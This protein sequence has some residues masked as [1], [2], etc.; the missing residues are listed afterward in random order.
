MK[1]SASMKKVALVTGGT[2][3][4]GLA[5]AQLLREKGCIVY[6]LSRSASPSP[7]HI[8]CDVC[9]EV[10]C[11]AA[12]EAIVQKEGRLDILLHCAG[13]GISGA[14][15]FTPM[16]K[17]EQ[18]MRVNLL[19][20]ANMVNAC[21]APMRQQGGGRMVLTS[22]VAGIVPIP[23][24]TW[25][26]CSKAAINSYTMSMA[27]ELKPFHITLCAVLPGDTATGFT[28]ARDKVEAGDEVYG[29]TIGRS[30]GKMEQDEQQGASPKKVAALMV[31]CALKKR[32]KPFYVPGFSYKCVALLMRLLPSGPANTLIG[33]LYASDK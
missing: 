6:T 23:F 16:E 12:V 26:A 32:V 25:Y 3:G 8:P 4:I 29:G 14:G 27:N 19:G 28:A 20:T 30:V 17:A 21:I 1:E 11:K 13:Y 24:Q 22:S 31:R 10:G 33:L 15:E 9:D 5:A 7:T 2:S 18:Q